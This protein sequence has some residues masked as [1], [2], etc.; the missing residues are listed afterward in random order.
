[1]KR[2]IESVVCVAFFLFSVNAM[3]QWAPKPAVTPKVDT[4]KTAPVVTAP[5]VTPQGAEKMQQRPQ[6]ALPK[7]PVKVGVYE[8][9]EAEGYA[10]QQQNVKIFIFRYVEP[11]NDSTAIMKETGNS[12]SAD[13]TLVAGNYKMMLLGEWCVLPLDIISY[14]KVPVGVGE[15]KRLYGNSCLPPLDVSRYAVVRYPLRVVDA[16]SGAEILGEVKFSILYDFVDESSSPFAQRTLFSGIVRRD[17]RGP[18]IETPLPD[19]GGIA[20]WFY[21]NDYAPGSYGA[22]HSVPSTIPTYNL[23]RLVSE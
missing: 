4:S 3:S 19:P 18:F 9:S 1:M 17:E 13:F 23:P 11:G 20:M 22:P 7:Y 6:V 5:K 16:V 14:I 12:G 21:A 8:G 10:P 15:I 2:M